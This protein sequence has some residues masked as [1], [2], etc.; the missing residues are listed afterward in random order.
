MEDFLHPLP[1]QIWVGERVMLAMRRAGFLGVELIEVQTSWAKGR[2]PNGAPP[3]LWEVVVTGS[4]WRKSSD[5]RLISVCG[6]CGR[7]VFPKASQRDVDE[8][9]WDGSDFFHA[10]RNPNIVLV[11]ERVCDLLDEGRFSNYQCV[12]ASAPST[13]R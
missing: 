8:T 12:P 6:V 10:D 1:G 3:R 9:R 7:T 2:G 4:A 13:V 11:T 5:E